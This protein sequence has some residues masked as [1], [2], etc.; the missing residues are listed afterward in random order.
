MAK[1]SDTDPADQAG[2]EIA[3]TRAELEAPYRPSNWRKDVPPIG[4][5]QAAAIGYVAANW[6]LVQRWQSDIIGLLLNTAGDA[7]DAVTAELPEL[8]R[9]A[10]IR[11]LLVHARNQEWLDQWD[12]VSCIADKLRNRRNDAIHSIWSA[13][14]GGHIMWRVRA[15]GKVVVRTA[16]VAPEQLHALSE[17]ILDLIDRLV[18]IFY[19]ILKF[20]GHG[21]ATV[22]PEKPPLV[23]GQGREARTQAEARAQK[24]PERR[25]LGLHIGRP[26]AAT[27]T[28]LS[29]FR[30]SLLRTR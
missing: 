20:G 10:M 6:A 23:P 8:Q 2:I 1:S 15:K 30:T 18:D 13:D 7:T 28:H 4:K 29:T 3:R 22:I 26:R 5:D 16:L 19:K 11:S 9:L 17:E 27:R 25:C 12:E 21:I 14:A 24:K